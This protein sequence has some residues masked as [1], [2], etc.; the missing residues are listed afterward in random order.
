[1]PQSPT[2]QAWSNMRGRCKHNSDYF[3][4]GITV[5]VEWKNYENF[6]R[7]MGLKPHG[8]SLERVDN[9][10]GYAKEN[11][12][13]ATRSQQNF[14]RRAQ[15]NNTSG[16]IGVSY[17]KDRGYFVAKLSREI[18]YRGPSFFEA[19]CQ[20][21]SAENNLYQLFAA[22][23]ESISQPTPAPTVTKD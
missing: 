12:V 9:N 15:N 5:C 10:K 8:L 13:W 19:C 16:I 18:L 23:S 14:N 1:M 22:G 21:K 4:R 2:K 11:C 3:G 7:D 6:R 17:E 20:R